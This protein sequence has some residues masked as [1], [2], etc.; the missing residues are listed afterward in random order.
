VVQYGGKPDK[1]YQIIGLVKDVKYQDLREDFTPIVF[2]N[3]AQ[4]PEPGQGVR[5]VLRSDE[6]M[7]SVISSVKH[8]V[9]EMSAALVLQFRPFRT[10]IREGLLRERLMA[11]LSGF[12]G[13]LAA[14]L[15]MLGLYGVISYMVVRRRNEIGIRMALGADRRNILRIVMT[16][17]VVLL[18]IGVGIGTVLS[19]LA[20]KTATSL[21]FGLQARDPLTL[22]L[23]ITALACVAM[24]ASFLP[25]H[26][27]ATI[28]PM[29]ALRDE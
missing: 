1:I 15:A 26:R 13:L 14:V 10:L 4:N 20:A 5:I 29:Q 24:A 16:E 3:A 19:L 2:V 9:G 21:L 18:A 23:A 7:D 8:V 11:T 22:L 6:S 12:F 17:A 25:A 27:A 28:D